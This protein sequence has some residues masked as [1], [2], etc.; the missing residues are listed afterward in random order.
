MKRRSSVTRSLGADADVEYENWMR[1]IV[2]G[3]SKGQRELSPQDVFPEGTL[4]SMTGGGTKKSKYGYT[5]CAHEHPPLKI[6][7]PEGK[8]VVVYGGACGDPIH[9]KL[10]I[11]VALDWG[12]SHDAKAYPWHGTRQFILFPI[13]DMSVPKDPAEFKLMIEWLSGQ[14]LAGKSVHVGCLGGHGR[15]GM[16]LAALV[17]TI[18]GNEDAITYVRENYCKK[19]VENFAQ[20][21]WLNQHFGIK[22]VSGSKDK[23]YT[24]SG[25]GDVVVSPSKKSKR[26]RRLIS[27]ADDFSDRAE[28]VLPLR[29]LGNIWGVD[30]PPKSG[31]MVKV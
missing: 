4:G 29:T 22:A 14:L 10:D 27:L 18:S 6:T 16:V 11:Y 24:S 19:A 8:E 9:D 5:P 3:T 17:R 26:S 20:T 15:T 31:K 23:L 7:T 12:T 13:T 30:S 21:N 28:E 25:W 1:G 2:D